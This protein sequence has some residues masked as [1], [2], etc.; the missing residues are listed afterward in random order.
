[1]KKSFGLLEE[2]SSSKQDSS[3]EQGFSDTQ[4][5]SKKEDTSNKQVRSRKQDSSNKQ[6]RSSKKDSSNKLD[7]SINKKNVDPDCLMGKFSELYN[8][9]ND[10]NE[11]S[12][13]AR[14]QAK[15]YLN[16]FIRLRAKTKIQFITLF[17][18]CEE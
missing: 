13:P 12:H 7:G 17:K 10:S 5:I 11:Q 8:S 1:M 6:I 9:K 16:E 2:N 3:S 4:D 14:E 15:E 18:K